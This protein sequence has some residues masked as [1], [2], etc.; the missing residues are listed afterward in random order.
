M[1]REAPSCALNSAG[2]P[3]N[4]KSPRANGGR[5]DDVCVQRATVSASSPANR[6]HS[7]TLWR[8]GWISRPEG[9]TAALAEHRL[10]DRLVDLSPH[11]T[12]FAET[13]AAMTVL[14]LMITVDTSV[15]HLAGALG[16]PS[17]VALTFLP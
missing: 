14:D 11:L 6:N 8:R 15:A 17:W 5:I 9:R 2:S 16:R 13:A 10:G 7:V 4:D 1:G 3:R 12:D